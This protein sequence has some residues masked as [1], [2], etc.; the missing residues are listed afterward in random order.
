MTWPNPKGRKLKVGPGAVCVST[1]LPP[2]LVAVM[3]NYARFAG[4]TRSGVVHEVLA[5]AFAD[6]L[7][8]CDDGPSRVSR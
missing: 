6:H 8:T 4:L 5:L 1:Q 2:D 3:D 7:R